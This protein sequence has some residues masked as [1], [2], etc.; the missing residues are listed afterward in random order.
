MSTLTPPRTITRSPSTSSANTIRRLKED[1]KASLPPRIESK[2]DLCLLSKASSKRLSQDSDSLVSMSED[3][4]SV[5]ESKDN[6]WK[7]VQ[8]TREL[9]DTEKKFVHILTVLETFFIKPLQDKS[10]ISQEKIEKIFGNL[11]EILKV[12]SN[13]LE[14][15]LFILY[16]TKPSFDNSDYPFDDCT[17][18][19]TLFDRY[20][21]HAQLFANYCS[22][23]SSLLTKKELNI[24]L[25]ED[26]EFA[27]FISVS[28]LQKKKK[29]NFFLI[30][31]FFLFIF[32]NN[33]N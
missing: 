26:K 29:F 8:I 12:Q 6:Q 24:F 11:S 7:Q 30:F 10:I 25:K 2:D 19:A 3:D 14:Q 9:V 4:F 33:L 31:F 18:I 13:F 5:S 21:S 15:L 22:S 28:K 23:H 32:R 17:T 16:K 1:S 27:D 20:A